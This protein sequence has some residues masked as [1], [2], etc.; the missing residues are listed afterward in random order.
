MTT[1]ERAAASKYEWDMP[2]AQALIK[3]LQA[4]L[5]AATDGWQAAEAQIAV[6]N[7]E[8]AAARAQIAAMQAVV[9]VHTLCRSDFPGLLAEAARLDGQVV[10]AHAAIA[11]IRDICNFGPADRT[12]FRLELLSV[13]IRFKRE[14]RAALSSVENAATHH[15]CEMFEEDGTCSTCGA[16]DAAAT[17]A[18]E[19]ER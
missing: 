9:A 6:T 12:Q 14:Q 2:T 7:G 8:L 1:P 19:Q 3:R 4:E 17:G 18:G 15:V 5:A 13:L 10:A 16:E 11:R